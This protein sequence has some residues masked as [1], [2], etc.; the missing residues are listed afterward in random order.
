[1][2]GSFRG[3]R[4]RAFGKGWFQGPVANVLGV[5][6]FLKIDAYDM[7]YLRHKLGEDLFGNLLEH[8]GLSRF[9]PLEPNWVCPGVPKVGTLPAEL[10]TG[11]GSGG[12]DGS[13]DD[14]GYDDQADQPVVVGGMMGDANPFY[15]MFCCQ[16]CHRK[17]ARRE[18]EY[19][20]TNAPCNEAQASRKRQL[21]EQRENHAAQEAKKR[22]VGLETDPVGY[23]EAARVRN[24]KHQQA[25]ALNKKKRA[26]PKNK[27]V[28]APKP[29]R[30]TQHSTRKELYPKRVM[31]KLEQAVKL[32][33]QVQELEVGNVLYV[34]HMY[35]VLHRVIINENDFLASKGI[36][37]TVG[38]DG[39]PVPYRRFSY[40]TAMETVLSRHS[41]KKW[42]VTAT[43]TF[44]QG[45]I[46]GMGTKRYEEQSDAVLAVMYG[47]DA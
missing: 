30:P 41:Q 19:F 36:H 26:P 2:N 42:K 12:D 32:F 27:P 33:I 46:T 40:W 4:Y 7:L 47:N 22:K 18:R 31:D 39:T 24:R 9:S 15:G 23:L 6:K 43:Y 16:G 38:E 37:H 1:M 11:G 28:K 5:S 3:P 34:N 17:I 8:F 10:C 14:D 45:A 35:R 25:A 29:K 44:Q 20:K 13:H 21:Q